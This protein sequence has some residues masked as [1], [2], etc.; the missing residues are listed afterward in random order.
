MTRAAFRGR[1]R[2]GEWNAAFLALVATLLPSASLGAILA[3]CSSTSAQPTDGGLTASN[4]AAGDGSTANS[5]NDGTTGQPCTSNA[6]CRRDGGPGVNRCS[7][8]P[9]FVQ[10]IAG[11]TVQLW[12]TPV[13]LEPLADNGQGNC[14]PAPAATDPNGRSVHFCDGPDAPSS[15]G[16]CVAADPAHPQSGQGVCYPKCTF[17]TDAAAP[18]GCAGHDACVYYA[19]S[20]VDASVTGFG[21]CQGECLQDSDCSALGDEYACQ[22]DLGFCTT[23]PVARTKSVGATCTA[24]DEASGACSCESAG[25]AG[26]GYC[27]SACVAGASGCPSSWVCD[28]RQPAIVGFE[29]STAE[30]PVTAAA[31]GMVGTCAP[32]CSTFDASFSED[33]PPDGEASEAG[34]SVDATMSDGP[35]RPASDDAS[36]DGDG[37]A[38]SEGGGSDEDGAQGDAAS[39]AAADATMSAG[40]GGVGAP[41]DA[42][43]DSSANGDASAPVSGGSCPGT[44]MCTS[45]GVAGSDCLP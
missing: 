22:V 2:Q 21:F 23:G 14:D 20:L 25:S 1:E 32:R 29:G 42:N 43:V 8:D 12:P 18:S 7:N 31:M 44:T 37:D 38:G 10:T 27:T 19:Y 4:E 34:E 24:A 13:C 5:G 11:V 33:A 39:D 3:G 6:S 30:V 36:L 40:D 26:L 28:T 16:I 35:L 45:I 9:S 17:G 41:A 15:P